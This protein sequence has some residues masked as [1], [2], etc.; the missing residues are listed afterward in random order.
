MRKLANTLDLKLRSMSVQVGKVSGFFSQREISRDRVI[1]DFCFPMLTC[2]GQCWQDGSFRSRSK[3]LLA[4]LVR[5]SGQ[6]G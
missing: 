6:Q 4:Q 5:T 3:A 1:H 2:R